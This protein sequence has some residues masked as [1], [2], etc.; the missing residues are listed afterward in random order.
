M[1]KL[2]ACS[3]LFRDKKILAVSRKENHNDF[4]LIGGKVEENETPEQA[5]L[6]E[7]EE[8]TGLQLAN[9]KEVFSAPCNGS[10]CTTFMAD[11]HGEIKTDEVH[12]VRWVGWEDLFAGTFGDYN[13][14]LFEHLLK[15]GLIVG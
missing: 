8:E 14:Q 11:Y 6:R 2:S 9:L 7:T 1:T 5:V 12:I 3:L 10:I 4:G 13:K 15:Q